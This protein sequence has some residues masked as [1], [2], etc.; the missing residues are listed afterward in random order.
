[1][2]PISKVLWTPLNS[3]SAYSKDPINLE[4]CI[5]S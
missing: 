5:L 1:M 3:D 2:L 4:Q